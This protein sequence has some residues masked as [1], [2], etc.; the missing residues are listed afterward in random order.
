MLKPT[1]SRVLTTLLY[2]LPTLFFIVCYFLIVTSGEDIFQGANTP[3]SIIQDALAAFHHSA[4]LADM[5]AWS[6]INFF[7]YTFSFGIDTLFRLLDVAVAF[8]IFY[9]NTALALGRRPRFRLGDAATFATLFLLVFL[10]PHGFILYAGFSAIHNYLFI[11]F[12]S[13]LYL[14]LLAR[15]LLSRPFLIKRPLLA[16]VSVFL[17]GFIFGFASNTTA[18]IFLLALALFLLVQKIL[19]HPQP[20]PAWFLSSLGGIV[21]ALI[22]IY[23]VGSGLSDY[24]SSSYYLQSYDYLSFS[25]ILANPLAAVPKILTH[26]IVN[27]GRFFFPLLLVAVSA[28]LYVRLKTSRPA[29][30]LLKSLNFTARERTSSPLPPSSS[31]FM[32]SRFLSFVAP[33]ASFFRPISSL[34]PFFSSFFDGSLPP[35]KLPRLKNLFSPLYYSS[36]FSLCSSVAPSSPLNTFLALCLSFAKSK[37]PPKIHFVSIQ[38]SSVPVCSP[39]S[40]SAKMPLWSN[41]PPQSSSTTNLSPSA[42]NPSYYHRCHC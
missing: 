10:T 35:S 32:Y 29:K 17:L 19:K 22:L 28:F 31:S 9:L 40:I 8:S 42:P 23:V 26:L 15:A 12:F 27:F 34:S 25:D 4:R 2:A 16:S 11:C 39:L 41:G 13:T 7:D 5:Y 3:P 18:L 36:H 1:F 14:G 38:P 6:V 24:T 33:P 37:T 20:L 30:S 21:L